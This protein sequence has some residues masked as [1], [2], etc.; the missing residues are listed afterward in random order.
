[1]TTEPK[2]LKVSPGIDDEIGRI[3]VDYGS[4]KGLVVNIL[5]SYASREPDRIDAAFREWQE[6]GSV[7]MRARKSGTIPLRPLAVT[8]EDA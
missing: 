3:M 7:R 2:N 6:A 5:L 8:T 4:S 1:M